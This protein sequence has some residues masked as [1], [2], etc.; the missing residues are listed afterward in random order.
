M[1]GSIIAIVLVATAC[2]SKATTGGVDS[3][4]DASGSGAIDAPAGA[5]V[6]ACGTPAQPTTCALPGMACCDFVPGGGTDYCYQVQGGVCEGGQPIRC[7]GPE[8][9]AIAGESCCYTSS[10]GSMCTETPTCAPGGGSIMCHVGDDSP[11]GGQHCCALHSGGASA[12]GVFG[13]CMVSCPV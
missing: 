8:D 3:R 10:G 4:F 5:S 2:G 12:G 7:D 13:I 6:V 1:R 11:C 9:C